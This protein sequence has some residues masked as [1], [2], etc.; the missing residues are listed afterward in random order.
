[1]TQKVSAYIDGANM[2]HGSHELGIKVDYAKLKTLIVNGRSPVDLNFYEGT[3]NTPAEIAFFE[4]IKALGYN[5]KINK[6]HTYG[7]ESSKEKKIDT[8]IVADS[9]VDGLVHKKMD[10][11]VFCTG[12]KDILPAI[13]YLMKDGLTVE[14]MSFN[15][16]FAWELR[17]CGASITNLTYIREQ[18]KRT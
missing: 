15:S 14:I 10:I 17:R 16:C 1:M 12:D 18:I 7:N 6:L 8:Q 5:L 3:K 11:A 2:Y 4:N 13:E 9:L